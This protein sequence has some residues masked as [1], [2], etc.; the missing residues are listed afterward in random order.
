[1]CPHTA[2]H[3]LLYICPQVIHHTSTSSHYWIC[4]LIL[5]YV[6]SCY[7]ASVLILLHH[8]AIYLPSGDALTIDAS[9]YYYICPHTAIYMCPHTAVYLP[10]PQ[11]IQHSQS[12]QSLTSTSSH[13]LGSQ[14]SSESIGY[15][16]G[17][18][19]D[20]ETLRMLLQALYL[21]AYY[22]ICPHTATCVLILLCMCPHTLLFM[23]PHTAVSVRILLYMFPHAGILRRR[24]PREIAA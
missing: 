17:D 22:Y 24:G 15:S 19:V 11:V 4:V 12:F 5:S 16:Q 14:Q 20:D 10:C 8:A 13:S 18:D 2:T 7:Y 3:V 23:C 21:S 1:M 6:S 9:S